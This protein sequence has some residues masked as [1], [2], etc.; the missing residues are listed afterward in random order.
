MAALL[1]LPTLLAAIGITGQLVASRRPVI[2]WSI[3]I[4]SQPLW[5]V[6]YFSVGAYPLML[7]STGY[8]IAAVLHLRKAL[9]TRAAAASSDT[10]ARQTTARTGV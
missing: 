7:L 4:G 3:S 10:P 2:G 1:T 8:L 5:Y 9:R 6:F